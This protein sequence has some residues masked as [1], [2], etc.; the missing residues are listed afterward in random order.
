M[1]RRLATIFIALCTL[2]MLGGVFSAAP[3]MAGTGNQICT[4]GYAYCTN[5]WN[6]GPFIKS[7]SYSAVNNDFTWV[8]NINECNGGITTSTC[9]GHGIGAGQGIGALKFTGSGAWVGRCIGDAYNDSGRADSSLDACPSGS[10][11]GG[12]GVNMVWVTQNTCSPYI[13]L[14]DI[15]WNGYIYVHETAGQTVYLNNANG[16]CMKVLP[17]A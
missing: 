1:K 7:Y 11:N 15:H 14:Y 17:P 13:L 12:W 16:T 3:A 5:A 8:V 6:G 2:G 10:N 4:I 9:P